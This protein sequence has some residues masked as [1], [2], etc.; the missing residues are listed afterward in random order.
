MTDHSPPDDLPTCGKGLAAHAPLPQ[1]LGDL[2]AAVGEILELHRRALDLD[3]AAAREEDEAYRDLAER[4]RA[5][6]AGLRETA[7]RMTA[8]RDLPMG[9]H[10]LSA[11]GDA[12]ARAAFA[13]FVRLEQQLVTLLEARLPADEAMLAEMLG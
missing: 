10:D 9:R 5:A 12:P 8:S 7:E 6:A 1:T 2:M 11:L 13:E 3:D 4:H